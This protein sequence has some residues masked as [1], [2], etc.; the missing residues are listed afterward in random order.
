MENEAAVLPVDCN[1]AGRIRIE[2]E[3]QRVPE[4]QCLLRN[5]IDPPTCGQDNLGTKPFG[6]A[7]PVLLAN[8]LVGRTELWLSSVSFHA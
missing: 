3:A 8:Y 7:A 6:A 2:T 1:D 4:Q 5:A